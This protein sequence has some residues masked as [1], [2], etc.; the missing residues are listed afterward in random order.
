MKIKSAFL[1]GPVLLLS[2]ALFA[3]MQGSLQVGQ[4]PA[5][6]PVPMTEK[7]VITELKKDGAAQLLK[8][9]DKRGVSFETDADVEKSL[10]KAK[11]TDEVVKA[12]ANAG[13]KERE[14][15]ARAAA[16][17][18]GIPMPAPEERADYDAVRTELNPDKVI[19]LT[20]AFAEKHPHSDVLSY[21]YMYEAN[22]YQ[23]KGDVVKLVETGEKSLALKKDNLVTL[24]MLAYAI[25]MPQFLSSHQ[26]DEEQQLNRAEGYCQDA[27]KGVELLSKP[28]NEPDADFAKRKTNFISGI[29]ADLGM[30]H[31]DRAQLGLMGLDKA[32]LAKAET[33]YKQAVSLTDQPEATDFFRLG[34]VCRLQGK[35]DDAITAYTKASELGQ[36]QVKQFADQQL[37]ALKRVKARSTSP[38]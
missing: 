14:S 24:G 18:G 38:K 5:A 6:A 2:S 28:P 22:A 10:R 32:E 27:L 13:P 21:A 29:H 30:I 25:P 3:Q 34:D 4:A 12:V 20:E 9:L 33:E 26:R 31:L 37:E 35:L 19:T 23:T 16:L 36:G 8:D 15:A 1:V 17:A 7:E 11:A